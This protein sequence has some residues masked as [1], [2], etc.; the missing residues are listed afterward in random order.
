[1]TPHKLTILSRDAEALKA[2]IEAA[3]KSNIIVSTATSDPDCVDTETVTFLLADPGLAEKIIPQCDNLIWCQSTWAGVAPLMKL[4]KKDY[5]LSGVKGIFGQQMRDFVFAYLLYFSR[6]IATFSAQQA[7]S[8]PQWSEA[9]FDNLSG[10][11]LGIM[12][13]GSIASALI[14][15]AKAFDMQI[16]GLRR[17]DLNTEGFDAIY[18]TEQRL[19]FASQCD[20]LLNLQPD[21]PQTA[22]S[23]NRELLSALPAGAV[24]INAGRGSAIDDQ[25]L[26]AAL[27][28][29]H[30]R[31]AVLD[32]F[33]QEPLPDSHPFWHHPSVYITCHT[34]A[35][36]RPQDIVAVFIHNVEKVIDGGSPDFLV[37]FER[38]Y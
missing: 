2:L 26:L 5:L 28:T 16:I 21:T 25:A 13:A 6:N 4:A 18:T 24:L 38:G 37:D 27:D 35:I 9:P 7:L 14:P 30:L 17:Q 15:A 34:A 19:S 20:F 8:P 10:K 29:G 31:A 3:N 12:G 22:N 36:S 1:M 32:V 33:R 23:I 11:T